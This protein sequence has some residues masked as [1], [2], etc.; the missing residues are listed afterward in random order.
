MQ[1]TI[2]LD[3]NFIQRVKQ[4]IKPHWGELGWVTYKRTYARWLDD[5]NRSENWD[6]TVKRVIEGNINLDPR[7][8]NNPS[9]AVINELTTEAQKLFRLTYGLSATP[10]GRNLWISGT[11]YQK[12]T[13]DSLNN[14]W[15]IAIRPQHY[16]DSHLVPAYLD[17][18]EVAVSMPF[19]FLFDQLMK[20][21]GVGFSVVKDNIKQI[22]TVD[23][24][25]DL[26]VVIDKKSQSYEPSLKV[27]AV[28]KDTWAK[29]EQEQD[30]YIY[31]ELPDTREGWILANARLIDMHFNRNNPEGKHKLVL[32]IS[33]IRPYGA[34][35]HGFGG[36]ASGPMPLVE[37]FLDINQ[38]INAKAGQN[39]SAVDATDICNLIGKTVVAGNVRRSAELALGSNDDQ[40]FIKMK[41]DK[42]KLYHHRW[43]SNN[44][45]AINSKFDNYGPIADGILHNGEPGV[46]NLE[47]SRNYG[48][49]ADGYQAGID[50]AVEGTNPCGEISLANGEPCNLFEVF[51]FVAE[52]QGWNLK[53][54]FSL[55]VR[56]AKRV[57]FS[58]YDWEVSRKIIQ[59]NRRIGVSM[60]GIQ[61]W[62]LSRFGHR[63]VT[64][65]EKATDEDGQTI[66]KP[67]YDPEIVKTFDDL[68]QAILQAD[69]DYSQELGCQTSVKHTTVK[70]SG[71]VAKLAGVS[72]GMHFH[73]A[74][75]LIQRIR[76]QA[77]DPLLPALKECGYYTEPDIYTKNTICVEFPL[78][79]ANAD[80]KNFASA[81]TVSIAEQFATQAFLQTY[82]SDNAVSCTIT[83]QDK[84]S[85]EIEPL[86]HQYRHIIK[87]TSLLPYYGGSL[88]QAPKEP[89]DKAK[90]EEKANK[91]TGNVEAVFMKENDD[92]KDLELVG[93]SDCA[94]GACPTK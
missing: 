61:D 34:K 63:V 44:S 73:Y 16:G 55:A 79:A 76:F 83:F 59:K 17:K 28:D 6:E 39:L 38:V 20:G 62:I 90:Y 53:E 92:Q 5:K 30:D 37:M 81:G 56:F 65:F 35:I 60:S 11:D 66:Q 24:A 19:S 52:Q 67:I 93:Q 12:R 1:K 36:T 94:G 50:D 51:P 70:P 74:G 45:V 89:I 8:K 29:E 26:T 2:Q 85:K 14:C 31:Y 84:E 13:G 10:S 41:Q 27:G 75:Y 87:S 71:T 48:R 47:L 32:D 9:P 58:H 69:Q 4:Q 57:T 23:Q 82:W 22:P 46:V 33:K 80:S 54:S 91:I 77:S 3:Q 64:G 78:R 49:I 40:D 88:K 18:N 68:Y 43:A 42:E 7:L 21:G 15:F 86:L 25:V 72:E